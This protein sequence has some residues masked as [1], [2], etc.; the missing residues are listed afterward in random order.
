MSTIRFKKFED[1]RRFIRTLLIIQLFIISIFTYNI[2]CLISVPVKD[3][4]PIVFVSAE[5]MIEEA[6]NEFYKQN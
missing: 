5:D 6:E 3:L 1:V 2:V 4:G